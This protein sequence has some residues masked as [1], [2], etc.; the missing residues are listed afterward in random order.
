MPNI[1][2]FYI[3]LFVNIWHWEKVR[4]VAQG[5]SAKTCSRVRE[6]EYQMQGRQFLEPGQF[7]VKS[8]SIVTIVLMVI[9]GINGFA[10]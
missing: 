1:F 8:S 4:Q 3:E 2:E 6:F 9:N 5:Q 10:C 7:L